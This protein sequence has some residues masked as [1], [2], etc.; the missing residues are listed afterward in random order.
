MA[1][2]AAGS[3]F[4]LDVGCATGALGKVLRAGGSNVTGIEIDPAA[5]NLAAERL[6]EVIVGDIEEPGFFDRFQS[7]TFDC[8]IFG[9]VLE[10]LRSPEKVL[11]SVARLLRPDGFAVISIP[12]VAHAAIR[13]SLLA[14][15]FDYSATGLLDETHLRFFTRASLEDMLNRAGFSVEAL[16]RTTARAFETEIRL[17]PISFPQTLLD[18]V[19]ESDEALTYQFVLKARPLADTPLPERRTATD[20]SGSDL[21]RDEAG[22]RIA[23]TRAVAELATALGG[24]SE[25]TGSGD[26]PPNYDYGPDAASDPGG[27]RNWL[28]RYIPNRLCRRAEIGTQLLNRR[29]I[30]TL[31]VVVPVYHADLQLMERC[32]DSVRRQDLQT[33]QLCLCDDGSNDPALA[34]VLRVAS[35]ADPRIVVTHRVENGGISAATNDA[36]ALATGEFIAFLDQDD[37]LEP[38]ILG[39]VVLALA[40][41]PEADVLYTDEDKIDEQGEF[42]EP[43]FKPG[44]SPDHLLSNMYFGHLFVVRRS[45]F[46]QLGGL[47]SEFD[48]SQD[49]DLALRVTERARQIVHLP[50]VGYHWRKIAGSTAQDYRSK[51]GAD[52]AAKAALND[53]L[54]R[55]RIAGSV[56]KGLTEST[57][58]VR[59]VIDEQALVSVI[60]PF[61]NGAELL[62][63]C[64][65]SLR[66]YGGHENW[67]VLLVDNRSWE[68]ETRAILNRLTEDSRCRVVP[69]TDHFNWAALNNFAVKRSNG[70]YLLFLNADVESQKSG[71]LAAMV[72]QAQRPEVGAVGARLVY[73]DGRIQH[74]GVVMGLGGGV[75]GHAFCFCPPDRQGYFGLDRVIRNYSAVT[76][77]CMM[78]RR[79]V[80]D[81]A[82]GF[83]EELTVAYNDID[84]CL[85]LRQMGYLNVYTPFAELI[86]EES[87]AR[88][89]ASR[90]YAET[91]IMFRRWE[92]LIRSDPYFNPNLDPLRHE[93]SLFFGLGE[94][95]PWQTL[96]SAA[97]KWL[98]KSGVT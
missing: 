31:S 90:E 65:V 73:P 23:L 76:G 79:D 39:E 61:H 58:R 49:Y 72:E 50:T 48:G 84:F 83:D 42:T 81:A 38:G 34:E 66:D 97:E 15:R 40:D 86:H 46:H 24:E 74:A 88:G 56:E 29:L 55:R 37:E 59:R 93:F 45:L 60:V 11:R 78:V 4:V 30:P 57:F 28:F 2:F 8:V 98:R 87:A 94:E 62:R 92:P 54:S 20:W 36:V 19:E 27:Y 85:R 96:S 18:V 22:L 21:R 47:R 69:Y 3:A 89:R 13:L 53:A 25:G 52:M 41:M 12:N 7:G 16:E 6:D 33:W 9:D 75:A 67:E 43:Y 77:A 5:A 64:V 68:P 17:D 70:G 32:I 14:G 71:W 95:D 63:R 51:P 10:H 91:A 82:G 26:S 80:F 35:D 1:E 44:W